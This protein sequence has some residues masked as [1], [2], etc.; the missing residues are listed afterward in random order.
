[1]RN[2]IPYQSIVLLPRVQKQVFFKIESFFIY[3]VFYNPKQEK[4]RYAYIVY[5]SAFMNTK[6]LS[7]LPKIIE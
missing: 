3:F 4:K 1:M 2:K 5:C 7:Q 6:F